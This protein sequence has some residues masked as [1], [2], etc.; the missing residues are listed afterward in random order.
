MTTLFQISLILHIAGIVMIAGTTFTNFVIS[1]QFWNNIETDKHKA[2]IINSTTLSLGRLTGI[3]GVLTILSGIAMVAA[4][5]GV[6]TAQLWFQIKMA[7]VLLIILNASFFARQQNKKLQQLL[8]VNHSTG[9][10]LNTI[11]A[12]LNIYYTIQLILLLTIF[13]LSVFKFN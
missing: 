5:H 1:K 8:S 2:V 6:F 4:L 9:N 3:G 10:A 11:K 12:N 7:L 13:V